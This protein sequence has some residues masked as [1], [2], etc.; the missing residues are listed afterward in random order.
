MKLQS[1]AKN[2]FIHK[3]I[4]LPLTIKV[5]QLSF[6]EQILCVQFSIY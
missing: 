5:K 1:I 6:E 4:T 3:S 2:H